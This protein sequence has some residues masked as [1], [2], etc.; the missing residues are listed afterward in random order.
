MVETPHL[1]RLASDGT[2]FENAHCTSPIC[3]PSR[4]SHYLGEWERSQG[5]N[6][7]GPDVTA[8]TWDRSPAS[9]TGNRLLHWLGRKKPRRCRGRLP[10]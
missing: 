10:R 4:A 8:T 9:A 3:T 7:N 1:D 2:L 6:F 5:H